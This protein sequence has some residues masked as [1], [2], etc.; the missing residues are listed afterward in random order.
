VKPV[1][2]TLALALACPQ[3]D[4]AQPDAASLPYRTEF[5]PSGNAALDAAVSAGSQLRALQDSAP[6]APTL[7]SSPARPRRWPSNCRPAS[8]PC[9][10]CARS[11][12]CRP[13]ANRHRPPG[14][15]GDRLG[16]SYE[17]EY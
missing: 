9:R 2:P 8:P 13:A 3:P 14:P 10:M 4:A 15:A 6:T 11:D 17:L 5:I 12:P 7:A 1:S 16:L